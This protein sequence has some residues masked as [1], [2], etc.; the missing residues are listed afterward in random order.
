M[1]TAQ[2]LEV[3]A[4]VSVQVALVICAAGLIARSMGVAK[5]RCRLWTVCYSLLLMVL[6]NAVLLPHLR[7]LR[8]TVLLED[9]QIAAA[10][11]WELTLGR[12]LL[13]VWL[14][15]VVFSLARFILRS[16]RAERFLKSCSPLSDE[17]FSLDR[18]FPSDVAAEL[19]T[20][21]G[22]KVA[23]LTSPGVQSPVC[24]QFHLPVVVI[25]NYVLAFAP[26]QLR[27]VLR[28]ELEH[29]RTGHPL[30]VFLQQTV[31]ILF[32]FHP[33]VWWASGQSAMTREFAC[34]DAAMES[35]EETA[36]Y[37]RTL[38]AIV[39][40]SVGEREYKGVLA[41]V[42]HH[43][44]MAVRAKRLVAFARQTA[45]PS[46]TASPWRSGLSSL[47]D[48]SLSGVSLLGGLTAL[49][50][51]FWLPVN[52]SASPRSAWSPWPSW[53]ASALHSLGFQ[54]RDFEIYDEYHDLYGLIDDGQLND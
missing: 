33:M 1:N 20:V 53:S 50:C 48:G 25:P 8:R 23:F 34:D 15:G 4:S 31:E 16:V 30:Q 7:L 51:L 21:R 3:F 2:F 38:L 46:Q 27:F 39:E 28:H 14:S 17:E 26:D 37:L 52:V 36:H 9:E 41:F 19:G 44:M 47:C 22:K 49:T 6:L 13:A 29:L 42:R 35:R 40:H 5:S 54:A 43:R 11:S 18:L 32:W 24:W 12:V 10:L 45:L